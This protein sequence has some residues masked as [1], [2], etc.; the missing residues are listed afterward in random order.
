MTTSNAARIL[1][2]PF[3][4]QQTHHTSAAKF[5]MDS[6]LSNSEREIWV[7]KLE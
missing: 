3:P 2:S 6:L 5:A 7:S 4:E 1:T